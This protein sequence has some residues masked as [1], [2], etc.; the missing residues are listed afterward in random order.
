MPVPEKRWR[1]S[2]LRLCACLLSSLLLSLASLEPSRA[3][4]P[5][6]AP[7]RDFPPTPLSKEAEARRLIQA[8]QT[9]LLQR[10]P[11]ATAVQYFE[12]AYKL[13]VLPD[14]FYHLGQA[15]QQAGQSVIAL[16]Y[17]QRYLDASLAQPPAP[18]IQKEINAFRRSLREP[19][20]EV[21]LQFS[22][23]LRGALLYADQRMIGT[24]PLPGTLLLPVGGHEIALVLGKLTL[25]SRQREF[26]AGRLDVTLERGQEG[27]LLT[28]PAFRRTAWLLYEGAWPAQLQEAV[29]AALR[30]ALQEPNIDIE[31]APAKLAKTIVTRAD[32]CLPA[33]VVSS[34]AQATRKAARFLLR[35][36]LQ[37]CGED[38]SFPSGSRRKIAV[39][40][41]DVPLNS[42]G[43]AGEVPCGSRT[44]KE[45]AKQVAELARILAAETNNRERGLVAARS[46][47]EG[48]QVLLDNCPR[49][50]TP[51][52]G[53]EAFLGEHKLVLTRRGFAP[54][55]TRVEITPGTK[56]IEVN[57]TLIRTGRPPWRLGLGGALMA[58]G[59]VLLGFGAAALVRSGCVFP[60]LNPTMCLVSYETLPVGA[61]L[62][63]AS[64]AFVVGGI[65]LVALPAR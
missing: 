11:V 33:D 17:Y 31:A 19:Y 13:S 61:G 44:E 9:A 50:N 55:Q 64:G 21:S 38:G 52:L 23:S 41:F 10:R 29:S 25:T 37:S 35:L 47:P 49:S 48:A 39:S 63:G 32:G 28:S 65:L 3:E 59:A 12:E 1:V 7:H 15:A 16:D 26:P 60:E 46:I 27:L 45:T 4:L 42:L 34:K 43:A 24:L 51:V 2:Q 14:I 5:R 18:E 30:A 53:M 22:D 56:P 57:A 8:G 6:P 36:S 62:V 20:A 54:Y 58:G 40:V